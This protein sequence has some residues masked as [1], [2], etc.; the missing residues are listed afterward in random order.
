MNGKAI[1]WIVVIIVVLVGGY[2]WWS[3]QATTE[4]APAPVATETFP[5]EAAPAPVQ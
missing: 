4:P 3:T 1:A 2:W 5:V